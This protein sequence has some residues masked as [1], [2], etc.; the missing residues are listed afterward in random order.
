[1]CETVSNYSGQ[2]Q[3]GYCQLMME[4]G[5]IATMNG[6]AGLMKNSFTSHTIDNCNDQRQCNEPCLA[7]NNLIVTSKE[8]VEKINS[9]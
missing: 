5:P 4:N 1:M 9:N 6:H 8:V 2:R 7:Y 3:C